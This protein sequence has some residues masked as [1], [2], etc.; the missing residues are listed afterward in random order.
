MRIIKKKN[1]IKKPFFSI[2]TVVKN[3]QKNILKTIKSISN[4][5][6]K[7]FEY[8]VVDGGSTD[9]TVKKIKNNTFINLLLSGKDKGIYDAMNIGIKK[10][11]GE[12]ILFV[13]S[14]D[15]ITKNALKIINKKFLKNK[16]I[17]FVFG[18]VLRHYTK[19]S[20]LKYGFDFDK[21]IYNFDFATSHTTGFFLKRDIYRRIGLYDI[22]FKCSADYDLYYRLYKEKVKGTFTNKNELIGVVRSGG[23][24]SQISFFSHLIEE[25]KIRIKN[26]QNFLF[27]IVIFINAWIKYLIKKINL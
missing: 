6:F 17:S 9:E 14:G 23:F 15:I 11:K 19:A 12:V 22:K 3:D 1:K 10:S 18:T 24:S 26:K 4:Q 16:N 21:I 8:V 25:T 13:N 7:K 2:I 20:I 27:V 5:T